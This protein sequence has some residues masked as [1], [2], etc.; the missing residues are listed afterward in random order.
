MTGPATKT[1][2]CLCGAVAYAYDGPENWMA[3]CHCESCRRATS[4]AFTSYFGV[5]DGKWRWTGAAPQTYASSDGVVR[6][7]CANC[8][9]Q[10]AYQADRYAG[11]IHFFAA[12]LDDQKHYTPTV[13]VHSDEQV[14]WITLGDD[15]KRK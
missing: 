12:S 14:D 2:R 4:A 10:M 1:G 7:F 5:P 6:S 13:H 3:H 15:L 9:S 8:G 11:E